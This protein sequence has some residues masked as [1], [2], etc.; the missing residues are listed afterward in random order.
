MP[1]SESNC[2]AQVLINELSGKWESRLGCGMAKQ[3]WIGLVSVTPQPGNDM[4]GDAKGAFVNVL[5]FAENT[6][7]YEGEARRALAELNLT[8]Y[9]FEEVEAFSKRIS[10]WTVD[11]ELHVLADEVRKTGAP[12][13][14]TFHNY[15]GVD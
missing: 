7:E 12:R 13:F 6:N 4:L 9:E 10:K 2:Q 14:G 15:L 1:Q 11:K 8:A 5:A 3:V